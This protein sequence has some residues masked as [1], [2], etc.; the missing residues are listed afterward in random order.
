MGCMLNCRRT[1]AFKEERF[2]TLH[3]PA[4]KWPADRIRI[5]GIN[6]PFT[7]QELRD[8][9][10]GE[11]NRGYGRFERDLYGVGDM[12]GSKRIARNWDPR[13]GAAMYRDLEPEI[14]LLLAW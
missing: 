3:A 8:T 11:M 13:S 6:P 12:L 4:I 1:H 2:L 5:Q 7:L 14:E 10:H 9:Q